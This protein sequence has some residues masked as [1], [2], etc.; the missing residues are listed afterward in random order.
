MN[1]DKGH[2]PVLTTASANRK[3]LNAGFATMEH[4]HF[5]T[6][7]AIVRDID[8]PK[9]RFCMATHFADRLDRTNPKFDRNRFMAACR[10]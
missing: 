9:V 6:I 10:V 1:P 5:A 4:R 7:A 2:F 8:D 3:D